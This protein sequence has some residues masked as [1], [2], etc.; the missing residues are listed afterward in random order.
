LIPEG[1]HFCPDPW[2]STSG[3]IICFEGYLRSQKRYT[4]GQRIVYMDHA[5][6][7]FTKPEVEELE[8]E[9]PLGAETH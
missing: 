5:A 7:S 6:T 1:I 2:T 9:P 4:V 8:G 3:L